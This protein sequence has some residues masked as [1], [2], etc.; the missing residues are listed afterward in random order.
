MKLI[1]HARS[2]AALTD[3]INP[4]H[5]ETMLYAKFRTLD[6]ISREVFE[7]CVRQMERIEAANPGWLEGYHNAE[8]RA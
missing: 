5:A 8:V 7:T 6:S 3:K 1:G 4:L 2:I